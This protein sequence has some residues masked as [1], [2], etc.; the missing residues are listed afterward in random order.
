MEENIN[1]KNI[2]PTDKKPLTYIII[3]D[4]DLKSRWIDPI[5]SVPVKNPPAW[6]IKEYNEFIERT[7]KR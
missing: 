3:P 4:Y 7:T 1:N 2:T 6:L 5:P